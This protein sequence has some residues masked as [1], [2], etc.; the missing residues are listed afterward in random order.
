MSPG[1][2]STMSAVRTLQLA[3]TSTSAAAQDARPNQKPY[4]LATRRTFTFSLTSN[5]IL[6]MHRKWV[7]S[8]ETRYWRARPVYPKL[9]QTHRL[10][11]ETSNAGYDTHYQVVP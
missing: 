2:G 11:R 9:G 8:D 6:V 7:N 4:T 10:Y 3:I 1:N 5:S